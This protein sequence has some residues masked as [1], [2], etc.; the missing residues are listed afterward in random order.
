MITPR[1]QNHWGARKQHVSQIIIISIIRRPK[2]AFRTSNVPQG[3]ECSAVRNTYLQSLP[4]MSTWR[5]PCVHVDR[6][7]TVQVDKTDGNVLTRI[8]CPLGQCGPKDVG[9]TDKPRM[10]LTDYWSAVVDPSLTMCAHP[11]Q[12]HRT[13]GPRRTRR[14]S[15][16]T[17]VH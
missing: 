7:K 13:R 3:A 10:S 8:D 14:P 2:T 16:R 12:V 11:E 9:R 1:L 17:Y 15:A 6:P 5:Q 4:E